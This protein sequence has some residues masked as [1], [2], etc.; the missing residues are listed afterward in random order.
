MRLGRL[1]QRESTALTTQG[2]LVRTQY[3][4]PSESAGR[5]RRQFLVFVRGL[6]GRF[7]G[8]RRAQTAHSFVIRL[9]VII[10]RVNTR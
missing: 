1:A 8:S 6:R 3:R 4:P 10:L 9:D 2:S 7:L 5:I